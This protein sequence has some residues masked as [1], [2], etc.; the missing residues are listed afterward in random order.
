MASPAML[1]LALMDARLRAIVR[2][3]ARGR[4]HTD[5]GYDEEEE[6]DDVLERHGANGGHHRG[7]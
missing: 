7:A 2:P 6:R 4:A 3:A 5:D 1:P